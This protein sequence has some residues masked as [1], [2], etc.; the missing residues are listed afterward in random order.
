[1]ITQCH[2]KPYGCPGASEVVLGDMGKSAGTQPQ[3]SKTKQREIS[4]LNT[5]AMKVAR[6]SPGSWQRLSEGVIS[7]SEIKHKYHFR[8]WDNG[9]TGSMTGAW[10]R[11]LYYQITVPV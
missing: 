4:P 11:F 7:P 2:G 10:K 5:I 9:C 1:M 8:D 6:S 3:H